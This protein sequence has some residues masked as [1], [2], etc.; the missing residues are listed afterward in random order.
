C[1]R[2]SPFRAKKS[3]LL[4]LALPT[5]KEVRGKR[6]EGRKRSSQIGW[7]FGSN[8]G[9]YGMYFAG[10]LE[11][12]SHAAALL[13]GELKPAKQG[14]FPGKQTFL[15]TTNDLGKAAAWLPQSKD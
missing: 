1:I 11:C 7:M 15:F 6:V 8:S 14:P 10:P 5:S 12:G 13:Y 9:S 4:M 3:E 2:D